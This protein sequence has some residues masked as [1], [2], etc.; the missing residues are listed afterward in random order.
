ML[1][2]VIYIY[3]VYFRLTNLNGI[4]KCSKKKDATDDEDNSDDTV[5]DFTPAINTSLKVSA[6]QNEINKLEN[7]NLLLSTIDE[8]ESG[9]YKLI[10]ILK[11]KF[12]FCYWYYVFILLLI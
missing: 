2:I 6:K 12:L 4:G 3:F 11:E 1:R 5:T 10:S 7:I 9:I 8:T